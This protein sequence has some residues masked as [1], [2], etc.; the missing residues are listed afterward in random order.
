MLCYSNGFLV[1]QLG[2]AKKSL[3]GI[4]GVLVHLALEK[5]D[6]P[7]RHAQHE[8]NDGSAHQSVIGRKQISQ[9]LHGGFLTTLKNQVRNT[10]KI[11]NSPQR[12]AVLRPR[13]AT[14]ARNSSR[15][16]PA[17]NGCQRR[18]SS[19][20]LTA[21]ARRSWP[22]NNSVSSGRLNTRCVTLSQSASGAA[23]SG[24]CGQGSTAIRPPQNSRSRQAKLRQ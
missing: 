8:R 3:A 6:E 2:W 1:I 7:H 22:A 12:A 10:A 13:A 17:K 14:R 20:V 21:R 24:C 5:D 15:D 11:Q 18:C 19:T 4:P 16:T 9:H 23:G